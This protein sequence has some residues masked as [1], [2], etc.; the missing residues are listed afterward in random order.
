MYVFMCI[1]THGSVYFDNTVILLYGQNTTSHD[2]T[3]PKLAGFKSVEYC[4]TIATIF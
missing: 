3:V 2:A 4:H 1:M